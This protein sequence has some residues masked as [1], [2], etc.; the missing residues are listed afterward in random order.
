MTRAKACEKVVTVGLSTHPKAL[1]R[2]ANQNEQNSRAN[3]RVCDTFHIALPIEMTEGERIATTRSFLWQLT[4]GGRAKAFAAFHGT[5]THNPHIHV[6]YFDR[7]ADGKRV[8][9]MSERGS[10]EKMR[11]L[12]ENACNA[13]LEEFGYDIRID[14]RTLEAQIEDSITQEPATLDTNAVVN[15]ALDTT[16]TER[17]EL[18]V[19]AEAPDMA[20]SDEEDSMVIQREGE[21]PAHVHVRDALEY[22]NERQYLHAVQDRIKHHKEGK[23]QAER[24]AEELQEIARQHRKQA[25]AAERAVYLTDKALTGYTKSNGKLRGIGI[26]FWGFEYK[27]HTRKIG[28]HLVQ[29]K[30]HHEFVHAVKAKEAADTTYSA[31]VLENAARENKLSVEAHQREL[32]HAVQRFGDNITLEKADKLLDASVHAALDKVDLQAIYAEF[33]NGELTAQEAIRAF[34][35]LGEHAMVMAVEQRMGREEELESANDNE[36][37]I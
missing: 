14:R 7:D 3:A 29:E 30:S 4:D 8:Q 23:A 17:P 21:H 20:P 27:N 31:M 22:D 9:N 19:E 16:A 12:W 1:E 32:D 28:E 6:M 37:E 24:Q 15:N 5:D 2:A 25:M 36:I 33:E 26:S 13:K 35:L 18:P 10:T 11:L 34:E